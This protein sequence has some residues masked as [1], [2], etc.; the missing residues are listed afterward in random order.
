MNIPRRSWAGATCV[1]SYD[2][3]DKVLALTLAPLG[4]GVCLF[5][6]YVALAAY[7]PEKRAKR[8]EQIS[9]ATL[10]VTFLVFT[11]CSNVV[12]RALQCDADFDDRSDRRG[13]TPVIR[14]RSK[15]H[16]CAGRTRSRDRIHRS[17]PPREMVARPKMS[18]NDWN[19]TELR[20]L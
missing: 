20:P 7:D 5:L 17:R 2:F 18:P 14:R 15:Q 1:G 19:A 11:T 6:A 10:I 12:I 4:V 9:M 8:K 13:G 16:G 3:L